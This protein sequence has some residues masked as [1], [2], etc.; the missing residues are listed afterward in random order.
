G[1]NVL[2]LWGIFNHSPGTAG[3]NAPFADEQPFKVCN[4]VQGNWV[5]GS[6]TGTK[7]DLR[8]INSN[9]LANLEAVVC[10][11]YNKDVVVEVSL[12]D[13]WDGDWTK[14]PFNSNNTLGYPDPYVPGQTVNPGLIWEDN[15]I[16]YEDTLNRL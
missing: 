8:F 3:F 11:A 5:C 12:L 15:F 14:G 2:R 7:W 9:Y 4:L 1:N 10:A 16:S 6:G 13:P